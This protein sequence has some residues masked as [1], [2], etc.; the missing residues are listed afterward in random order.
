VGAVSYSWYLWHWPV[1]IL[2]PA[3]LG[4]EP[5]SSSNLFSSSSSPI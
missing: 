1:L 5:H 3:I 2:M 4:W